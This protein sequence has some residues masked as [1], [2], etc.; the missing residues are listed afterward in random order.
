MTSD[1]LILIVNAGSSS[2]KLTAFV[3]D[4]VDL[5]AAVERT[6]Q[7]AVEC[8][9]WIKDRDNKEV[10][11]GVLPTAEHPT[12]L[13]VVLDT[14]DKR[15]PGHSVAAIGHRVVHGGD[16]FTT[17]VRITPAVL[18]ALESLAPLAPLHQPNN[19]AE[20]RAVASLLPDVPQ[21]ACFDTAFHS[22]MP[23]H[24]RMLGLPRAYFDKGVMRYGFHGLSYESIADRLPGI[25]RRAAVGRTVVCHLGSGA[26][27]CALLAGKSVAT[28]MSFTPLDG[29]LMSTRAGAID[30]G[31]VLYLLRNERLTPDQVE[32]LL[33]RESGLLGVSGISSDPRDLLA[34]SAP[35]AAEAV[36]LFCYRV[37]REIGAMVAAL[38]G[39][40]AIVF[41]GGI[42]ENSP[43]IRHKICSQVKWL[44]AQLNHTAN[45]SGHTVLNSDESRVSILRIPADEEALIARHTVSLVTSSTAS[46]LNWKTL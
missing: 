3:G 27:L 8:R 43:E 34:S 2:L 6:N 42:G 36:D 39:L 15:L 16:Q 45:R 46:S 40:D 18:S 35:E 24:E 1:P 20:I 10:L 32:R 13:Q 29:L 7:V 5:R 23:K 12:L 22:T 31:V 38:E 44:G 17:P 41:T 26:S 11:C 30:A 37:V 21:V 25:D 4:R 19:L 33:D 9:F 14:C 28:T